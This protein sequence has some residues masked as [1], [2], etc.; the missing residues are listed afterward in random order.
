MKLQRSTVALVATALL[1]GGVVLFTQA[2]QSNSN[3]PATAPGNA[4]ASPVFR[5]EEADVVR[6][7]I[8]TQGQA[9]TFEQ[10]DQGFWQ[11]TSPDQYPAEEAAI[12]FL[13][14]RLTTDG[15]LKTTTIDAANQAEFGLQVPF[16]TVELTLADG[17]TH[18]LALGDAD[19]SGQNYYAL[20]DPETIPLAKEAGEVEVAIVTENIFNGVN[21]PLEEWKA[22]VDEAPGPDSG[23]SPGAES[24]ATPSETTDTTPEAGNNTEESGNSP[25]TSGSAAT[26]ATTPHAPPPPQSSEPGDPAAEALAEPET[27]PISVPVPKPSDNPQ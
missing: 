14:S 10:D 4:D 16:A 17:S 25:E 2:Q 23:A 26:P 1:L 6:L 21:R 7:H 11:M 20:I 12:A 13:L 5:F 9:V 22:V 19:F 27:E 15:L 24:E 3:R 8:E 18:S